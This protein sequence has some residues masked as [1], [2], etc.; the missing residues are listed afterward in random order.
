MTTAQ[1]GGRLSALRTGR[2]YRQ[3]ILLVLISVRPQ[4]HS[5]IGR[6]LYQW[7]IPMTP[8]GNEPAAFRFVAQHLNH[9]A[10]AVLN[11]LCNYY[12]LLDVLFVILCAEIVWCDHYVCISKNISLIG[13]R[14]LNF[15]WIVYWWRTVGPKLAANSGIIIK[16]Y[17]L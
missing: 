4:G 7:K 9:C 10:T 12:Q 2:L 8:S 16:Y 14:I 13:T 15:L 5:A 6:I 11:S 17:I 3:E 1:D